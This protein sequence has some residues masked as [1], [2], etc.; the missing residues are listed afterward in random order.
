MAHF[1]VQNTNIERLFRL[2]GA[3]NGHVNKIYSN[4]RYLQNFFGIKSK[5]P[6]I[7]CCYPH[8]HTHTH[9]HTH[10]NL[11][12]HTNAHTQTHKMKPAI[13]IT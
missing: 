1:C 11:H 6:E 4:G 10:I 9:E 5:K 8:T 7:T 13:S 3:N 12:M 2:F